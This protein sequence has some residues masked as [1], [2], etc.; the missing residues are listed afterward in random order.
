MSMSPNQYQELAMQK[1]ADQKVIYNRLVEAGVFAS[2]LHNGVRGLSDEVGELNACLK[3]WIEYGKPLNLD[4]VLEECGDVLWRT[5]QILTTV[6]YT[7]QEALE[8]NLRKLNVRYEEGFTEKEANNRNLEAEATTLQS[9]VKDLP[10][11]VSCRGAWSLGTACGRCQKCIDTAP[12]LGSIVESAEAGNVGAKNYLVTMANKWKCKFVTGVDSWKTI[13][14]LISRAELDFKLKEIA[15]ALAN[16]NKE[17]DEPHYEVRKAIAEDD[18]VDYEQKEAELEA[19]GT[20]EVD[21]D[22]S[23]EEESESKVEWP[24][25]SN[26][27]L[28]K[29]AIKYQKTLNWLKRRK[30]KIIHVVE[31][32][33]E[34]YGDSKLSLK[35]KDILEKIA[36]LKGIDLKN[37]DSW[38]DVV[39]AII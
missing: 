29:K 34:I 16:E 10:E 24:P 32:H 2:R 33:P 26:A 35:I 5:A 39:N 8:A 17:P 4:N 19:Y 3:S 28:L 37:L 25:T 20:E 36:A 30:A 13:A 18:G 27:D 21:E 9:A 15:C 12:K 14:D 31:T 23:V 38:A 6:G 22:E 11:G 7:L 1:E